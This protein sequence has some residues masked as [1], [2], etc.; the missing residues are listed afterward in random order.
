MDAR[1]LDKTVK[2]TLQCYIAAPEQH[3]EAWD[4]DVY[5]DLPLHTVQGVGVFPAYTPQLPA[6]DVVMPQQE[7]PSARARCGTAHLRT[8]GTSSNPR[9]LTQGSMYRPRQQQI[10]HRRQLLPPRQVQSAPCA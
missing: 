7:Q 2:D 1:T 9:L 6:Q 10:R 3:P 5:K 8:R 4:T